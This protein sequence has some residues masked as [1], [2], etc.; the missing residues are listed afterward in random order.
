[1]CKTASHLVLVSQKSPISVLLSNGQRNVFEA[2][3]LVEDLQF[4]L[5]VQSHIRQRLLEQV[6]KPLPIASFI[7]AGE[8]GV[9]LKLVDFCVEMAKFYQPN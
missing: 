1:M 6:A 5:H 3:Q 4:K 7:D 9:R 2:H 8:K